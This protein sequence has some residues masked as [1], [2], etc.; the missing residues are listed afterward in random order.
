MINTRVVAV[1]VI[2][3]VYHY[4]RNLDSAFS[5][6]LSSLK[7]SPQEISL[8]KAYTYGTLR[9]FIQLQFIVN[10]LLN[11]PIAKKYPDIHCLL[12]LGIYEIKFM[13]KPPHAVV[14]ESV[15]AVKILKKNWAAGLINKIL[16]RY[17]LEA[18]ELENKIEVKTWVKQAHPTWLIQLYQKSWPEL[19]RS[20]LEANNHPAPMFLR[21]NRLQ[22]TLPNYLQLLHHHQ[23]NAEPIEGLPNAIHIVKPCSVNELPGFLAGLCS[24]QDI[25]GQQ[26]IPLLKLEPD[27]LVLDACAAPGSKTC[28]M[29]EYEL[30]L[31]KMISIDSNHERLKLILDNIHRLKLPTNKFELITGDASLPSHWW[32]NQ[33]FD[34]ILL[35]APCSATGVI[36]RHPDYKLLR[37]PKDI[38]QH[39]HL[40]YLLISKLW[41]LLKPGGLLLYTTCSILPEENELIIQ[42][43]VKS[44]HNVT[45]KPIQ[46]KD[47]IS[48]QYGKQLLPKING[49]DG[50]YYSLLEKKI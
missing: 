13:H 40:Q 11:K 7:S 48:L 37:Q 4:H 1:K 41:E 45:L 35:D 3:Q 38:F 39:A 2:T 15:N 19:W 18:D 20:I 43:F 50:F 22:T 17:L 36:R 25:S 14:N 42:A 34:R 49:N 31:K 21:I 16:K 23:I 9:W 26:V 33:L 28:H 47:A 5:S 12:C 46:I 10:L 8:I 32:N 6:V 24:V 44:H 29:L 30:R 27:H